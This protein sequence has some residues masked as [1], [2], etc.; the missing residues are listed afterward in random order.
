MSSINGGE[1]VKSTPKITNVESVLKGLSDSGA[2][3]EA[4]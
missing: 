4:V 2:D 3:T 1:D